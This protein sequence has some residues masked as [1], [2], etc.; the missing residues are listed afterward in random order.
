MNLGNVKQLS[1]SEQFQKGA[2]GAGIGLI[3]WTALF[4][5]LMSPFLADIKNTRKEIAETRDEYA[6]NQS[7][8][9]RKD[10]IKA[11]YDQVKENLRLEMEKR[12]VPA[13]SYQSPL[14]WLGNAVQDQA[15]KFD[16]EVRNLSKAGIYRKEAPGRK[17]PPPLFEEYRIN[18]EL[19][20]GYHQFGHFI[21]ALEKSLPYGKVH[22]LRF[23]PERSE[24]PVLAIAMKYGVPKFTEEGFPPEKRP[25]ASSRA[26][27]APEMTAKNPE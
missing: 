5:L 13:D 11:E 20:G 10:D 3:I 7:L 15:A 22:S 12:L 19:N 25:Q 21:A 27:A 1:K 18:V 8:I 9:R 6:K 26:Q 17:A 24:Q 14:S 2:I 16:I 4:F 23:R